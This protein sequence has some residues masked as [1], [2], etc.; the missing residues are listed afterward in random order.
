MH[1][2]RGMP[3]VRQ[4][5]GEDVSRLALRRTRNEEG[6]SDP[7]LVQDAHGGLPPFWQTLPE[8]SRPSDQ[9]RSRPDGEDRSGGG[10]RGGE[11]H[12]GGGRRG[13]DAHTGGGRRGGDAR[14]GRLKQGNGRIKQWAVSQSVSHCWP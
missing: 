14:S 8:V 9:G 1:Q 10:R 4:V 13:G 3:P 11:A 7:R 2:P 12:T 6:A 5:S